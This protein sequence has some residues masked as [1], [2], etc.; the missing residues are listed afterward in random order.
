MTDISR[1]EKRSCA[2]RELKMRKRL[3]PRWVAA[4][5]MTQAWADREI[6]VMTAIMEDYAQP[7]LFG[8][9]S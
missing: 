1:D 6:L 8:D 4:G 3:Y 5:K 9:P 2:E 7:D